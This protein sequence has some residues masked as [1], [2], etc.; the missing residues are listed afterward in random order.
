[1]PP[2]FDSTKAHPV[3]M[4][5]YG[6]PASPQVSDAWGGTRFLWHQSLTQQGDVVLVVDNRGA[7]WRG[8]DF[9]KVTQYRLG[10]AESQDQIDAA[11]WIAGRPW[12]DRARV[13]IWG[14]SYGGFMTAMS[15][16]RGGATFKAGIAVAPVVDWRYYDTIY[17][18]R[19]MSTP[20]ENPNGYQ[21]GAVGSYVNNM[22]ARLLLVHGTGD[23]NV[24]PQN[25]LVLA[26]A[27][28]AAN[29]P[30]TMLL[31]PN[32]THSISG[33]RTQVHLFSSFTRFVLENL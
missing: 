12:A 22:T 3:L 5:V 1:V 14:W 19:F 21:L 28:A 20:Q 2:R 11:K 6:G 8:R 33:G 24:H 31:Y 23:D 30:F 4:Y 15:L 32:R 27:L 16:A 17:T 7:A 25:S 18:E 10:V 9:R 26:D 29:K 13:G